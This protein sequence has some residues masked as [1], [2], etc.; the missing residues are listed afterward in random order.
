MRKAR[1]AV[2]GLKQNLTAL[3]RNGV[4]GILWDPNGLSSDCNYR[5]PEADDLLGYLDAYSAAPLALP[6][7]NICAR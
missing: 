5:C 7:D 3:A 1:R 6:D 2:A 4:V